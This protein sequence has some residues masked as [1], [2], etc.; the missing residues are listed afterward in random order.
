MNSP[1][2]FLYLNYIVPAGGSIANFA[3]YI[4]ADRHD[5]EKFVKGKEKSYSFLFRLAER[6][7]T[8]PK[9][10]IYFQTKWLFLRFCEARKI[11]PVVRYTRTVFSN[12]NRPSIGNLLMS[13]FLLPL[14]SNHN[15]LARVAGID[16]DAVVEI[17]KG[18]KRISP[19][20]AARFGLALNT[21]AKYWLDL[22]LHFEITKTLKEFYFQ[23]TNSFVEY[24]Q[25]LLNSV[26]TT[27]SNTSIVPEHPG[28]LL[29]RVLLSK[30]E[31]NYADWPKLF[32]VRKRIFSAFIRG[33]AE[34]P[35]TVI[36]KL[37]R[38]LDTNPE[39]WFEIQNI[40]YAAKADAK[41]RKSKLIK[42]LGIGQEIT[43]GGLT[44]PAQSLTKDFIKPLDITIADLARHIDVKVSRLYNI[45]SGTR[46]DF[47]IAIKI[48]QAF[49]TDPEYWVRLQMEQD[50][51]DHEERGRSCH[52]SL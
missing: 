14:R 33:W 41:V 35:L 13:R 40:F 45:I 22:Q 3:R 48:A 21:G 27:N 42:Q 38:F 19:I 5:V 28:I 31:V 12:H 4:E 6:T 18:I 9:M 11:D 36:L 7:H 26:Q 23:P 17:S 10:W 1:G 43:K 52:R 51:I 20:A 46:M 49:G 24:H 37:N 2:M 50:I 25:S 32:C 44:L 47:D 34:I 8:S 16:Y 15:D 39:Y 30:S 29:K